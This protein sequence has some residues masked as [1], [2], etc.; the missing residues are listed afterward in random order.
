V[1]N[2]TKIITAIIPIIILGITLWWDFEYYN[3]AAYSAFST[4]MLR[5]D[6]FG[7]DAQWTENNELLNDPKVFNCSKDILGD[8]QTKLSWSGSRY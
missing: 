1:G 7:V 6:C 3:R 8:S 5:E 4:Q 2:K